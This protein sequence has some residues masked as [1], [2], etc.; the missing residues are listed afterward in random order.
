MSPKYSLIFHRSAQG[1]IKHLDGNGD[2]VQVGDEVTL[3][4]GYLI[5]LQL[6]KAQMVDYR[7]DEQETVHHIDQSYERV[8]VSRQA[9]ML[10]E[11]E[12][13]PE[14]SGPEKPGLCLW[15]KF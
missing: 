6:G 8:G 10:F 9:V 2:R 1:Q 14:N 5:R 12:E 7:S 15:F 4:P 13:I 3:S 11:K